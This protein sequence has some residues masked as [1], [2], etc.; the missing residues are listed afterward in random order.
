MAKERVERD[1]E[2]LV[3]LYLTD[4]GQYQ[5]LNKELE[6][7]LAQQIENG[8]AAREQMATAKGLTPAKKREL[9]RVAARVT[10]RSGGS[11]SRTCG[12]WS[13]S[14]RSTRPRACRSW[15]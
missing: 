13:R 9:R 5:L 10:R 4:I 2:D 11:S 12:S 7:Q 1:E 6:V 8:N 15:T 3:R 14:P